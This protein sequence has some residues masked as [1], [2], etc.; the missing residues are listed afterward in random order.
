MKILLGAFTFFPD[1][2]GI[3]NAALSQAR[4]IKRLGHAVEVFT[5]ED[6]SGIDEID[7]IRIRRFKITGKDEITSPARGKIQAFYS[8]LGADSW[9]V[10]ILNCWHTWATHL[11]IKYFAGHGRPE[12]LVVISH[13]FAGNIL[14]KPRNVWAY[15]KNRPFSWYGLRHLIRKIDRLVVLWDRTDNDRF[16]D[17][18]IAK[19][20]SVRYEVIPN[21]SQDKHCGDDVPQKFASFANFD[22]T[23]LLCVGNYSDLKN[24][25]F[26]L[27]AFK[28]ADIND[29]TLVFVGHEFNEYQ[30]TLLKHSRTIGVGKKTLFLENLSRME[31]AWL[32]K[33]ASVVLSGSRT[34]CQP[35]TIVDAICNRVPFISTAVGCVPDLKGGLI[36][37]NP[38][39]MARLLESVLKDDSLRQRLHRELTQQAEIFS[40]AHAQHKFNALLNSLGR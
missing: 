35:L 29:A 34:E 19:Q 38:Q 27:E 39:K 9:D 12:K 7:G 40:I 23:I 11:P 13:G 17:L 5:S 24:E 6:G 33:R 36:A 14:L 21:V 26:V 32:Y 37:K 10:V 30:S 31:I 22:G 1:S 8:Y 4:I 16:L 2:N 25:K 3:A 28:L 20:M 15:V 18:K